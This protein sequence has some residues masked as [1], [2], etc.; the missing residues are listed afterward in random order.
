MR[1]LHVFCI[2]LAVNFSFGQ[3]LKGRITDN[4]G[5]EIPFAKIRVQGSSY[6][7]VSSAFGE[8]NLELK[9]GFYVLVFSA[10]TFESIRDSMLITDGYQVLNVRLNPVLQQMDEVII[11]NDAKKDLAKA[12]M[13]KVIDKRD[14]F[15]DLIKEYSCD[16]YCYSSLEKDKLDSLVEDSIIGREKLNVL[17][18]NA[19]TSFKNPDKF[20]DEFYAYNDYTDDYQNFGNASVSVAFGEESDMADA[21]TSSVGNNPYLFV[22]G[23]KDAHFSLFE[24]VIEAPKLTQSPLISP[25]AFNAFVYYS[26]NLKGSFIDSMKRY[27]Y[28][29]EVKPR[30]QQEALFSGTLYIRDTSF[31]L[32]SYD[33]SINKGVLLFFKEMHIICDYEKIGERLV[34]VRREFIYDITEGKTVING[35]SRLIHTNYSF[36]LNDVKARFW[37]ERVVFANDALDKDTSYWNETRPFTIKEIEKKFMYQQDSII[38]YHESDAFKRYTD[39]VRNQWRWSSLFFGNIGYSNSFKKIEYSVGGLIQQIVLFG[40]GGYRHRLPFYLAKEFENGYKLTLSPMIDYG[41]LNKDVKGTFDGSIMYNPRN[42]AKIGFVIGDNYDFVSSALNITQ[43]ILP[44]SNRVRNQKVELSY[45]QELINGL[46]GKVTLHYSDRKSIENIKYPAYWDSLNLTFGA[47]PSQ[48]FERYKIMLATFDF[49]YHFKQKYMIRKGRKVVFGS[50][51]PTLYFQYKKAL[52]NVFNSEANFDKIE[53]KVHD[54]IKLNSIGDMEI[55]A[56]A[57]YFMQKSDIRLIEYKFFRQ[58]D[59]GFFSDP[60][61]T[62]QMLDTFLQTNNS[63]FQLN[64]I[65]HFNGFFL[66]KIPLISKLKLEETIGGGFIGIPDANFAQ[67]EFFAG[68][69]RKIR[70]KKT[71]FKIGYYACMQGNSFNTSNLRYKIGINF[72]DPFRD[73]WN[74]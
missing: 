12:I 17:E 69:E 51:W 70:I 67:V 72:Y 4:N 11:T 8:Y 53:L 26:Y 46:F 65:H 44:V 41:F 66:N 62:M 19:K 52:P 5:I 34:P 54:E 16:T 73:K 49:E 39:S 35:S 29:I 1:I 10:P 55:K 21:H 47:A 32:V 57:G 25:L 18:W 60:T 74:Y 14:F 42:F 28:E 27:I 7:T 36:D 23:I 33:L 20:K 2:L 64:F 63:Y 22:N 13:K 9:K 40:V 6:G 50:P 38:N 48:P 45:S 61:N 37:Q 31:E 68:L 56:I 24:N 71:V 15:R 43:S 59:L 30:F 3:V 58:S